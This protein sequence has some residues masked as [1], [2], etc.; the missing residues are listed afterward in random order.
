MNNFIIQIIDEYLLIAMVVYLFVAN[1]KYVNSS[2]SSY[3]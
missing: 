2:N 3:D 1:L